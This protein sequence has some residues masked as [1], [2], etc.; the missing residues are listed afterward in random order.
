PHCFN[1]VIIFR[2]NGDVAPII[3]HRDVKITSNHRDTE[4][5]TLSV[6]NVV[7]EGD[8]LNLSVDFPPSTPERPSHSP[9]VDLLFS[10]CNGST[11]NVCD[12]NS[13]ES[14]STNDF[15]GIYTQQEESIQKYSAVEKQS[16][17][18]QSWDTLLL[19]NNAPNKNKL[20][21]DIPSVNIHRNV[22]APSLVN[23]NA[24]KLSSSSSNISHVN[25]PLVDPFDDLT[26]FPTSTSG[27]S[28]PNHMPMSSSI[29][30]QKIQAVNQNN[31]QTD[32][33]S[34]NSQQQ[35]LGTSNLRQQPGSF[36]GISAALN[37]GQL[38]KPHNSPMKS[39]GPTLGGGPSSHTPVFSRP[40]Y[41]R[42]NFD[43]FP[44]GKP[45]ID[46]N[47]FDDLLSGQNFNFS[48]NNKAAQSLGAMKRELEVKDMDPN[49]TKIRDW[50]E[51]KQRNVRALLCSLHTVIWEGNDKWEECTMAQLLTPAQVKKYYR[52]ACLAIHPDKLT[53]SPYEELA[54]LIF[55]ELND[56]W[57]EFAK[58]QQLTSS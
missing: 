16:D 34:V 40:N 39:A 3:T 26:S 58:S 44:T 46:G 19:E 31:R 51:G 20:A 38:K 1:F 9:N 27:R 36:S 50:T 25:S 8:L 12:H 54:K 48:G 23:Q 29:S 13:K 57:N 24:H 10:D 47:A 33:F 41:S 45:R 52:K 22:S 56:A 6:E 2:D 55:T 28:S 53:G 4:E 15:F 18:M 11:T 21:M 35:N 30:K 14:D 42:S 37:V 7:E 43:S 49:S 5:N 17:L 32:N